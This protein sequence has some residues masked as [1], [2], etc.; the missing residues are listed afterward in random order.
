MPKPL[1]R[2]VF[3]PA[4]IALFTSG[5]F[6]EH[7]AVGTSTRPRRQLGTAIVH[8]QRT[9]QLL[10]F[11]AAYFSLSKAL[12]ADF[13]AASCQVQSFCQLSLKL[14]SAAPSP[15]VLGR[16]PAHHHPSPAE[17]IAPAEPLKL[18]GAWK[19]L[20]LRKQA[21]MSAN[22]KSA[23]RFVSKMAVE[24]IAKPRLSCW[25]NPSQHI[26]VLDAGH[27]LQESSGIG[28]LRTIACGTASSI[29]SHHPDWSARCCTKKFVCS[30]LTTAMK[31]QRNKAPAKSS[32]CSRLGL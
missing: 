1:H 12:V 3:E 6:H 5:R 10:Y 9:S 25:I 8:F 13:F 19:L 4:P 27:S 18:R 17:P 28:N 2:D 29:P 7:H 23:S 30:M 20:G 14:F 24:V 31:W 16:E 32:S 11:R 26:K 22:S 21:P 15:C